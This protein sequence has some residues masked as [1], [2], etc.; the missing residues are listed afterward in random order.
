MSNEV[1]ERSQDTHPLS[2]E[3]YLERLRCQML[4]FATLQL[5][6]E[7][8]AEDAV[9]EALI[10]ALNNAKTFNGN[11]AVKTWMFA[12]LKNKIAD[13]LRHKQRWVSASHLSTADEHDELFNKL[14][15]HKGNWYPDQRPRDWGNP[16]I[17]FDNEQ[18]W[19][20][21]DLCLEDLPPQQAKLFMMREFVDLQ[22]DEICHVTG[23]SV[24][25]LYVTLHRARLR[26]AKCLDIKWFNGEKQT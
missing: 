18:F 20:I 26:L 17:H 1:T 2:D 9:Q 14:F 24:S 15:D 12:I 6:D 25:N 21:F 5:G 22:T 8:L 7:S 11:A 10:G 16:E 23:V 19:R 3:L 13:T 4:K